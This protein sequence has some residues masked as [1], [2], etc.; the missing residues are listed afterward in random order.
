MC[1][2]LRA[3]SGRARG[4]GT[5]IVGRSHS[6]EIRTHQGINHRHRIGWVPKHYRRVQ[7]ALPPRAVCC[8]ELPRLSAKGVTACEWEIAAV[9]PP[10]G[11]GLIPPKGG[12]VSVLIIF[13]PGCKGSGL[14]G[15]GW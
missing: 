15:W 6:E 14:I 11:G 3:A 8:E 12:G 2:V 1:V 9:L 5:L 7:G 4:S 10:L 13:T